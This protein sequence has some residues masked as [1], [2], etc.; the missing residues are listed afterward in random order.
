MH[1]NLTA[2][3]DATI[4]EVVDSELQDWKILHSKVAGTNTP[5][6]TK[7]T[8]YLLS[9]LLGLHSANS[10]NPLALSSI[11]PFLWL[12]MDSE[13]GEEHFVASFL[14][15]G[16]P[17]GGLRSSQRNASFE[18]V[19]GKNQALSILELI[20]NVPLDDIRTSCF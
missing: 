1:L 13:H 4:K 3:Y 14:F 12:S 5:I 15:Q 18:L 8:G 7:S 9:P 19:A 2:D 6:H 20:P 17:T 16:A 11:T 10:N